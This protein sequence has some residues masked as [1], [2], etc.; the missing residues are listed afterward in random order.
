MEP[1]DRRVSLLRAART[2]FARRGY[3]GAQVSDIVEAADVARGTF[4][5]YFDGK[6]QIFDAVL[7]GIVDEIFGAVR[8]IDVSRDVPAQVVGNVER[9]VDALFGLGDAARLLVTD[10]AGVDPEGVQALAAF[11]HA[12]TDR[13]SRALRTGQQ[14]GIVRDGHAELIAICLVGMLKEPVFHA[15]I[16]GAAIDRRALSREI[17]TILMGGV[18][19]GRGER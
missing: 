1:Q 9:V 16:T 12:T 18:V 5:N 3:H 2:V 15:A 7:E 8:P 17:V 10:S 11:S 14:L 4:Y 13:I 19:A 6:R